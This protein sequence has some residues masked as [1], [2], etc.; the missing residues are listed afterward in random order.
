MYVPQVVGLTAVKFLGSVY[1]ISSQVRGVCKV[2]RAKDIVAVPLMAFV[3]GASEKLLYWI[4][5]SQV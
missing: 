5:E 2:L 1:I 3:E 4:K